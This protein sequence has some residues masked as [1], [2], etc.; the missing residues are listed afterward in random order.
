MGMNGPTVNDIAKQL[1]ISA[2]TVSRVLSGSV[3]VNDETRLRIEKVAR[4]MGY[5]KK[6]SKRHGPRAILTLGLFLPRTPNV[7]HQLF[8]DPADLLAGLTEGFG[9]LRT[10]IMVHV[11]HPEPEAFR[12]KKSG[13]LDA[14]V[15]GFTLPSSGV[16]Q[17][18]RDRGIP[19]I[20]LNR[21]VPDQSFVSTDHL[22]GMNQLFE[23]VVAWR[24]SKHIK[25]AYLSFTPA[26]QISPLREQA[27]LDGCKAYAIPTGP[28]DIVKVSSVEEITPQF[29]QTIAKTYNTLFCFNDFV[30]VYT[31]QSALLGGISIPKDLSIA[32]YDNSPIRCLT[33]QKIDTVQL[34]AYQLGFDAGKWLGQAIINRTNQ[35]Y[36]TYLPGELIPGE[37]LVDRQWLQD[38]HHRAPE[39]CL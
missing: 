18:L 32:G 30:A 5:K 15:F 31:Y 1:G 9:D 37:T 27:F 11:N 20:L 34:S 8:Y 12:S 38:H 26:Y 25:P 16:V 24:G 36:Q 23:R 10:Q 17:T 6:Q 4:E 33:P 13:N 2:S 22:P 29:I 3:L 28:Q 19:W 35:V 39:G 7:Y 14:V 21:E